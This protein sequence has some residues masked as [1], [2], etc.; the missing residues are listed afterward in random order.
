[1]P[2]NIE[3]KARA[4]DFEQIRSRAEALSD[5]PVQVI[6]QEDVFFNVERGRLKLRILAPERSEL[7]YYTRRDQEGPKRSD[8]HVAHSADPGNLKRVLELAYGVRGVVKKTRYLYLAGQTRIHL[9]DV[10]GLGHFME[11]EVVLE[12]GQS[13][14]EGQ[15]IAEELMS[16]LDVERGDLIDGAYMDLLEKPSAG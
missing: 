8:Y 3:V 14:A 13:E 10:Q 15:R 16:A 2:A 6:P 1:L 7:I 9:D 12:E 11:L 4:R 5:R